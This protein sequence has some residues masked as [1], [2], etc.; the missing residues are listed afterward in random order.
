MSALDSLVNA[1]LHEVKLH[2]RD[3]IVDDVPVHGGD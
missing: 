2:T 1:L 3:D